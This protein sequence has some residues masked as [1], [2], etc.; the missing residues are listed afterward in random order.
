MLRLGVCSKQMKYLGFGGAGLMIGCGLV[1]I[2]MLAIPLLL[3]ARGTNPDLVKPIGLSSVTTSGCISPLLP[4]I[5]NEQKLAESIDAYIKSLKPTSPLVGSG[6]NFVTG[7]VANGINPLWVVSIAQKESSFGTAGIALRGT[8][9]PFGR[10]ATSSQPGVELNGRRWY[11]Y[12]S[13]QQSALEHPTYL[14]RRYIDQGLT[15]FREIV[16]VYAPPGENDTEKYIKDVEQMI[17]KLVANAGSALDCGTGSGTAGDGTYLNVPGVKQA[18]GGDCGQASVLMVV[19][20][21]RPNFEDS[22]YYNPVTKSTKDNIACVTPTYINQQTGQK[23]WGY[24]KSAQTSLE[25]V[26]RSLEGGDPVVIYTR[27]GSIYASKHIFVIVGYDQTDDTF[28]VNNPYVGGVDLHTKTPNGK[29]M[30][31][32]HLARHFG[33]SIYGHAFIIKGKYR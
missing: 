10:T 23:D 29:K 22:R 11:K 9:N 6:T 27:A 19:L 15:T 2:M 31:A 16:Y 24:A 32:E 14:K 1:A 28:Y 7:G 3:I 4:T 12:D 26:K 30:T 21:Y 17:G 20:Y 25:N 8:N 5:A 18:T 33:D 13:F